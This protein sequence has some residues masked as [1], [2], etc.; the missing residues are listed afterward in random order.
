ME[1]PPFSLEYRQVRKSCAERIAPLVR[2]DPSSI[3]RYSAAAAIASTDTY[4]RPSLP[5]WNTT[6]PSPSANSVWF[7]AHADVTAGIDARAA[8]A[9]D[10]VAADHFLT[11]ELLHAKA[12]RFRIATVTR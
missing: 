9:N 2:D 4:L 7:L 10:D 1:A 8:L 6:R 5:V 12:L 11:A 3:V